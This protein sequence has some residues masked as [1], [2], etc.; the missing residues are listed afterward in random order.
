[1]VLNLPTMSVFL[2]SFLLKVSMPTD[3][4]G[5]S[6]GDRKAELVAKAAGA[7]ARARIREYVGAD[8][9]LHAQHPDEVAADL[10]ALAKEV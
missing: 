9:D 4:A 1:M 8:H 6:A 7:L 10:L 5:A 2:R 3:A